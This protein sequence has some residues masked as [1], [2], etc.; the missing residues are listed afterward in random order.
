MDQYQKI[1]ILLIGDVLIDRYTYGVEHFIKIGCAGNV[2]K[3][4]DYMKCSTMLLSAFPVPEMM[5]F[6]LSK[7][8]NNNSSYKFFKSYG[9]VNIVDYKIFNNKVLQINDSPSACVNI[10]DKKMAEA[11]QNLNPEV[12]IISDYSL[13]AIGPH[14][15]KA[16]QEKI[17]TRRV[18]TLIDSRRSNFDNYTGSCWFF[19]TEKELSVYQNNMK[20]R[21]C[22]DE[23][24]SSLNTRGV[25]LKR[26][27]LGFV[28]ITKHKITFFPGLPAS[29]VNDQY[30][31][32]DM[33]IALLAS[34]PN[35]D[36]M[37]DELIFSKLRILFEFLREP[38]GHSLIPVN[39]FVD[40]HKFERASVN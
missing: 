39:D 33:L 2:L 11:I 10:E 12:L 8:I 13:G 28:R 32:G 17:S 30:G 40:F 7:T 25:F 14:S 16:I 27:D 26:S 31:A 35:G 20:T 15:L 34:I 4:L 1:N 9:P 24:L 37:N 6:Y 21:I 19:P 38:G 36:L 5:D 22:F 3:L 29:E 18:L 23:L